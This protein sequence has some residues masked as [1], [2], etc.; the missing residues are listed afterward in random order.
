[1]KSRLMRLS[2]SV[3]VD[4]AEYK[5]NTDFKVWIEIEGLLFETQSDHVTRLA[6][7][8]SL[9]YPVLPPDPYGAIDG[10]V[11]FYTGKEETVC[12][13]GQKTD[14]CY[15]LTEDFDYIWA[16][17]MSQYGIDLS[18]EDMHWWKFKALLVCLDDTCRFSKIVAFR[19]M[20]TSSVKDKELRRFYEKMKKAFA[21]KGRHT[22]A[23][24]EDVA[25]SLEGLF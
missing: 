4:G 15:D 7:I 6:R 25:S 21:L 1:M 24:E 14:P 5:I 17:F 8:L 11:K 10:I 12:G 16:G 13:K 22:L 23:D 3:T 20:D 9:A 19:T 18:I 2:D